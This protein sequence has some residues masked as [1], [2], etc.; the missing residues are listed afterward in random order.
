[1][2]SSHHS[3]E[4]NNK[5]CSMSETRQ[6]QSLTAILWRTF[7]IMGKRV[8]CFN[9]FLDQYKKKKTKQ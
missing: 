4:G 2:C 5:V 1:M 3:T 7:C 6:Q 8:T 9:S